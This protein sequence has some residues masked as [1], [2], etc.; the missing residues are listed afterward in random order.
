MSQKTEA[1]TL[2]RIATFYKVRVSILLDWISAYEDLNNELQEHLKGLK[3]KGQKIL[4]P[5][6][7]DKI[8]TQI[9]E[10]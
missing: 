3:K 2:G 7:I 4:P 10:R 6:L 8:Y 9:G 5:A 1:I